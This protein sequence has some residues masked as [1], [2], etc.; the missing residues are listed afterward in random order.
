MTQ[1]CSYFIRYLKPGFEG[2]KAS[3]L[4]V[5]FNTLHSWRKENINWKRKTII[6]LK[7]QAGETILRFYSLFI[8]VQTEAP[9]CCTISCRTRNTIFIKKNL[10]WRWMTEETF[11]RKSRSTPANQ[12][13]KLIKLLWG[14]T[15]DFSQHHTSIMVRHEHNNYFRHSGTIPKVTGFKTEH[16]DQ[17]YEHVSNLRRWR[18]PL[19]ETKFV[20]CA[21]RRR[22]CSYTH[23]IFTLTLWSA[24]KKTNV[25]L[26]TLKTLAL[27]LE[28]QKKKKSLVK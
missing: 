12:E 16:N 14:G 11:S 13:S 23:K 7:P 24:L 10:K 17:I 20:W 15:V 26:S 28:T 9:V 4:Q 5:L 25:F 8:W 27:S 19:Y 22:L 6:P 18:G 3:S 1:N 2:I 21:A